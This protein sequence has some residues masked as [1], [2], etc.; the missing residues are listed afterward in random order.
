MLAVLGRPDDG[1]T[2][3]HRV[4]AFDA[5][6]ALTTGQAAAHVLGQCTFAT[7]TPGSAATDLSGPEAPE[8]DAARRL[9]VPDTGNSRCLVFDDTS[10]TDGEAAIT[11]PGQL[12]LTSGGGATGLGN[13]RVLRSTCPERP[14][15]PARLIDP[16]LLRN[17]A[18]RGA[19]G[20]RGLRG[21]GTRISAARAAPTPPR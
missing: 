1:E 6:G 11:A 19:R 7:T 13:N 14:R 20:G 12:D 3:D 10:L 15:A 17:A 18:G 21:C 9:Y 16:R 4:I 2:G 5:S 8:V